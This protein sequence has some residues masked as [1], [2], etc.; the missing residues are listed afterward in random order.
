MIGVGM[1]VG[2]LLGSYLA[3]NY[4]YQALFSG[5]TL[6]VGPLPFEFRHGEGVLGES[7]AWAGAISP[8]HRGKPQAPGG[9]RYHA[10]GCFRNW[11]PSSMLALHARAVGLGN[12]SLF[13]SCSPTFTLG[14]A[15]AGTLSDRFGRSALIVPGFCLLIL[16]LVLLAMLNGTVLLILSAV[17]AGLGLG[18]IN[19][20]LLAMVPD[21]SISEVDAA[22]D[23][24][25]FSNA[26][27]VGVVFGSLGL[28]A[29]AAWSY[30]LFW[31]AVAVL[32]VLGLIFY[33]KYGPEKDTAKFGVKAKEAQ[34]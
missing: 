20:V 23:L 28:S 16:G 1:T 25:F 7:Q 32:N 8:I 2:P 9:I 11:S 29:L 4:G 5:A 10:D 21:C 26:F 12:G 3:E 18:S 33:L 31:A 34:F 19:A 17:A 13:F 14:G 27:D 15:A 30:S 22:N 6:V 24:A